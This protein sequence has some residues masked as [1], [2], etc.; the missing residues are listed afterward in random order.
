MA[1][2]F[3]P[4]KLKTIWSRET[5]QDLVKTSPS[6]QEFTPIKEYIDTKLKPFFEKE[7]TLHDL[8]SS[9]YKPYETA[10]IGSQ[11]TCD[12]PPPIS[13]FNKSD[14]DILVYCRTSIDFDDAKNYIE[15]L[16]FKLNK[17]YKD[18]ALSDATLFASYKL[19]VTHININI[20]FTCSKDFFDK[21]LLASNICKKLNLQSKDDRILIHQAVMTGLNYDYRKIK[22]NPFAN[23]PWPFLENT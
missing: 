3:K 9:K 11:Y 20:I 5:P 10:F 6:T 2:F 23:P 18:L 21:F 19:I 15:S 17:P 8:F 22:F 14:F 16:G 4:Q 7:K 12:P 1:I 13:R